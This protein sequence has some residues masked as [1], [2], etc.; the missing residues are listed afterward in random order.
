MKEHA[1][2]EADMDPEIKELFRNE[3]Q[4]GEHLEIDPRTKVVT[5]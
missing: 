4:S 5:S 1:A 2:T 3:V